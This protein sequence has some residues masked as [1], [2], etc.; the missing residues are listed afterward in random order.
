MNTSTNRANHTTI[1]YNNSGAQQWAA[2][3]TNGS[4]AFTGDEQRSVVAASNIVLDNGNVYVTAAGDNGGSADYVTIKY[5]NS[6]V[7]QWIRT[8]DGSGNGVD[9]ISNLGIRASGEVVVR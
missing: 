3:F 7:Q 1:K 4:F 5:N 6:G 8:F 2:T 9:D